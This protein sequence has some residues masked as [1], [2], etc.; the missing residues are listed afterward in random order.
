MKRIWLAIL[1]LLAGCASQVQPPAALPLGAG[2]RFSTYGPGQ[3]PGEEYWASVG[4]Q[5][6]GRFPEAVP[7][8]IWI[9]GNIYGDGTYLNFP[10]QTED[11]N[12][13]C[14]PIDMNEAALD[15]FDQRGVRVWLQVEPGNASMEELIRIVM[16]HYRQHA[17][18]IGFGVDVE[19]WHST[20]GPLGVPVT[21]QEAARWVEMVRSYDPDYWLFLKHWEAEWMP[22]SIRDGILFVNDHQEF[23]DLGRMLDNFAAWGEHFSPSPVAY[24]FGYFSDRQW[25]IQMQDPPGEIGNAI[26]E[27]IPNTRA[28]FWVDF[29]VLYVFPPPK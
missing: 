15:L 28:L 22:P 18:V 25:W 2:F 20:D 8:T 9:V 29:T 21:D 3:N 26:L 19:W 17:S 6:A 12:I 27:R 10:C 13:R 4:E 16:G 11:P 24:Q 7:Q 23:E 14:G 5:M 1:L